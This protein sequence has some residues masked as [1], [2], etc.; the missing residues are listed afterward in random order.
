MSD[1]AFRDALAALINKEFVTGN[2]LQGVAFPLYVILPEGNVKWYNPEAAAELAEIGYAEL[3]DDARQAEAI[4]LLT[5][6]GYTWDVT[7]GFADAEGNISATPGEG[8]LFSAGQGLNFPNGD[9]VPQLDLVA[10]TASYDPLRATFSNYISGVAQAMG[11]PIVAIPTDFNKIV[12]DVFA[13]EADPD[14]DG[15]FDEDGDGVENEYLSDFDMFILGYSLGNAAFP[16]FHGA[17]FGTGAG[18][19]NTQY[20]SEEYDAF[21]A[22]FD[23]AQNEDDAFEAMWEM[24][25][26]IALDKPHIPLFDTGILEFYSNRVEYPF[27]DTLS[28]LQFLSGLQSSAAAK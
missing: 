11:I 9:P 27:T 13:T 28:G 16:T 8:L 10:P 18:D 17:F 25:R 21:S 15:V 3:E 23:S 2:L 22:A 24:E 6:A 7:P 1:R 19:N 12:A 5:E 14:G 4:R 26:L 20:S